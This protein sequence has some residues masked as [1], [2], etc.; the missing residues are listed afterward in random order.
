[1]GDVKL[2]NSLVIAPN[3]TKAEDL[4]TVAGHSGRF[5]LVSSNGDNQLGRWGA[6]RIGME[7]AVANLKS[8][9]FTGSNFAYKE[10]GKTEH[11]AQHYFKALRDG[12]VRVY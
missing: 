7:K 5:T 11:G 3:T 6:A 10:I 12:P 1:M 8:R 4:A 2:S 9:G